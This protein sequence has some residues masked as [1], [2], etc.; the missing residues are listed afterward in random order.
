MYV[1]LPPTSLEASMREGRPMIVR[2]GLNTV[3]PQKLSPVK[4]AQIPRGWFGPKCD[5]VDSKRLERQKAN[6]KFYIQLHVNKMLLFVP[7]KQVFK[8]R[9]QSSHISND[10]LAKKV[11]LSQ[12]SR[13]IWACQGPVLVWPKALSVGDEGAHLQERTAVLGTGGQPPTEHV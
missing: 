10:W 13:L 6:S 12:R 5:K 1:L 4:Q 11:K 3:R 2:Q 9:S 7:C 8:V